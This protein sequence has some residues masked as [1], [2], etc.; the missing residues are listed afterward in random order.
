MT[1]TRSTL[2]RAFDAPVSKI[3]VFDADHDVVVKGGAMFVIPALRS[4]YPPQLNVAFIIRRYASLVGHCVVCDS[5]HDG[6]KDPRADVPASSMFHDPEC[7]A[8][9]DNIRSFR[10]HFEGTQRGERLLDLD[11]TRPPSVTEPRPLWTTTED[12]T[13]EQSHT[14]V[15]MTARNAPCPCGSGKK[16]KH[17]HGRRE[18]T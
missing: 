16:Y 17:C 3:A 13:A 15:P 9:D 10:S 12:G 11:P 18:T 7:P 5:Y 4:D 6:L 1:D 14:L 8:T 2:M